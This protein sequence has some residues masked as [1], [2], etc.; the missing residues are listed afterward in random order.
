MYFRFLCSLAKAGFLL[1]FWEVF[2][3]EYSIRSD[4]TTLHVIW[5]SNLQD[6]QNIDYYITF[7]GEETLQYICIDL[8]CAA[9]DPEHPKTLLLDDNKGFDG[10][11][12][13]KYGVQ[14]LETGKTF[15]AQYEIKLG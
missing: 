4:S 5:N 10:E 14:S 13:D 15:K 12:K 1:I 6:R 11:L 8:S 9:A 2:T 7:G 3:Y